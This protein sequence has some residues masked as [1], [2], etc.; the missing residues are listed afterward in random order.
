LRINQIHVNLLLSH[1][2]LL[3]HLRQ[4]PGQ[5]HNGIAA[6]VLRQQ[7]DSEVLAFL[8]GV[9]VRL[10][11][12]WGRVGR[13]VGAQVGCAQGKG[14]LA[15]GAKV[16][17]EGAPDAG[18]GLRQVVLKRT[19]TVVRTKLLC[20]Q[21]SSDAYQSSRTRSGTGSQLTQPKLQFRTRR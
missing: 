8:L 20:S 6:V 2:A 4:R 15:E 9:A 10:G 12:L 7:Q 11:G 21:T 18:V 5:V 17:F 14:G 3:R 19:Y 1:I 13:G 16:G